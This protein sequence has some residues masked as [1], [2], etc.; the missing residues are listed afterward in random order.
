[1]EH[2]HSARILPH[3]SQDE[4]E[5]QILVA[6]SGNAQSQGVEVKDGVENQDPVSQA[7]DLS[8][9]QKPESLYP[10]P[11]LTL[12]SNDRGQDGLRRLEARR[13]RRD[14]RYRRRLGDPRMPYLE[15]P[16]Y[17]NYRA[18]PRRDTGSDGKPVWDDRIEE[19]FQNGEEP[20]LPCHI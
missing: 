5:R 19:A 11:I 13:R 16:K 3:Q 15:H 14:D 2:W 17:L 4:N 12:R 8:Q 10:A 7:P 9:S 6:T 18:R 1:M 20:P